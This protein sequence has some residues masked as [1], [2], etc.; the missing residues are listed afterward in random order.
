M[1]LR[2]AICWISALGAIFCALAVHIDI[3][4]RAAVHSG[5]DF[6][7]SPSAQDTD[8]TRQIFNTAALRKHAALFTL[9]AGITAGGIAGV[10]ALYQDHFTAPTPQDTAPAVSVTMPA[11][12]ATTAAHPQPVAGEILHVDTA[13]MLHVRAHVWVAQ[14]N[15][16]SVCPRGITAACQY[17]A[18]LRTLEGTEMTAPRKGQKIILHNLTRSGIPD[19]VQPATT[20]PALRPRQDVVKGPVAARVIKTGDGDTVQTEVD[21]WPGTRVLIDIRIG[22]IDTP[23]KKGRAKCTEEAAK[24]EEATAEMRRLLEGQ[25][26]TLHNIKYEKYGGRLLA[27]ITTSDGTNA[28]QHMIAQR[29]AVPYGGG[30]KSSWCTLAQSR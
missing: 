9:A 23:E 17:T 5:A 12:A 7:T 28:A 1:A 26:V 22:E 15:T 6:R 29:L 30:T 11:P 4:S 8:M 24:A 13:H 19:A 20:A 21:I 3:K 27:D 25:T 10:G 2:A 18:D 14:F 16:V